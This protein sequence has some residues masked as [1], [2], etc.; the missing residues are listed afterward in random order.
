MVVQ[1]EPV[2][3]PTDTADLLV[4]DGGVELGDWVSDRYPDRSIRCACSM[5]SG[6]ALLTQVSADAVL[7]YVDASDGDVEQAVAGLRE[8]AGPLARIVLVCRAE[9]EPMMKSAMA[10]GADDYVLWPLEAAEVERAIGW[11]ASNGAS[12]GA[13]L[14]DMGELGALGEIVARLD[15]DPAEMLRLLAEFLRSAFSASSAGV[16]IEGTAAT[17]GTS[18][19]E[20]VLTEPVRFGDR[21]MGHVALGPPRSGTFSDDV[22]VKLRHYAAFIGHLVSASMDHRR[23]HEL[24]YTDELSGLPNRRYLLET[25]D[26]LL[27]QAARDDRVV[28]LL[29]FDID[30]FKRYNDTYGHGAGDEILRGCGELFRA[31]CREHDLITRYGGDE[32]AVVFWDKEGPRREG[33]R[34]PKS[35]L[36]IIERFRKSLREKRFDG[37]QLPDGY[38]LTISGGLA[39]FPL[40]AATSIELI[41]RADDALLRAK[42]EGR[43]CIYLCGETGGCALGAE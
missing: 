19:S 17:A 6:T 15:A 36:P 20:P 33:S 30:F 12:G 16:V 37:F 18:T 31:N 42:R 25:L 35:V 29:M 23:W 1:G 5:L 3:T 13:E 39:S 26:T 24:A 14:P 40:D 8:A 10:A 38:R 22:G 28:T 27:A 2:P 41:C 32:F 21:S 7:A 43:N 4:T 34:H 9:A 11:G